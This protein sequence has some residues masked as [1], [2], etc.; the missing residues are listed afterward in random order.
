MTSENSISKENNTKDLITVTAETKIE[1]H[2]I[3]MCNGYSY[4]PIF[5]FDGANKC[6]PD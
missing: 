1:A 5:K 2:N 4:L 3:I 6:Y